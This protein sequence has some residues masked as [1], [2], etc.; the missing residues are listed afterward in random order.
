MSKLLSQGGYGC[1]YRPE[2]KC[3]GQIGSKKMVS[4][5]Q[6]KNYAAY[7]EINIS[8]LIR[9][10]KHYHLYFL[11]VIKSCPVKLSNI[12]ANI[13]KPCEVINQKYSYIIL[14]FPFL[15]NIAFVPF[16]STTTKP[17]LNLIEMYERLVKGLELLY[18]KHIVHHDLKMDNILIDANTYNPII[19]DYGISIDMKKVN[20]HTYNDIFYIYAPD[21]YPWCIE[22]HI[23]S[24]MVQHRIGDNNNEPLT[25]TE[26]Y[27]IID[28]YTANY[29][30]NNFSQD[31][32]QN[33]N[34]TLKHYV[35]PLINSRPSTILPNL[36]KDYASWDL[37]SLSIIFINLIKLVYERKPIPKII[38]SLL[39]ILLLNIS[40][41]IKKRPLHKRTLKAIKHLKKMK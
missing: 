31:F 11:P 21:Y 37:V 33:Y 5:I 6:K 29:F 34:R 13:L 22:Q 3:S 41:N 17:A 12:D 28:S 38:V 2:I 19:I 14:K 4:K 40:P 15:Q 7:N 30:F 1:V 36:I 27:S 32:I 20:K 10:I 23:I 9:K 25:E 24:Y 16:F 35:K 39:K 8:D 18:N 26:L